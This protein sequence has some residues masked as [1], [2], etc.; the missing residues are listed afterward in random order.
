MKKSRSL[1][2]RSVVHVFL[3]LVFG[4]LIYIIY[5]PNILIAKLFD[6]K[7]RP[8]PD[9]ASLSFLKR[10]LI[11][12]GPDLFWAYSFASAIFILNHFLRFAS[13]GLIF[14]C[15]LL[16]VAISEIIQL[17]I[18][19]FTFSMADTVLVLLACCLSALVNKRI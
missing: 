4:A 7:Q 13:H 15:V 17:F 2:L 1:Y 18:P 6:A 11:Y 5:R 8:V 10:V 19:Y 14:L 12:S 3:P 16:F 9:P